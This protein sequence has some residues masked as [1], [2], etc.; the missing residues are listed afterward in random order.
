[1]DV[2]EVAG[3]HIAFERTGAGPGLLLLHGAVCDSR[4]WRHELQ[5]FADDFTVVAWD[6]PG[7]G[8]SSDPPDHFRM[9]DYARCLGGFVDALGLS[10]VHVLGHSWG[11]A[12]A[13]ELYR[14][15]P[16]VVRSLVLAGAYAGW[17]GSLR[18]EEVAARVQFACEVADQLPGGFDPTSMRG[19]FSK[20][21]PADRAAE[22]Q[23]I[24]SEIR[25][26][27][28]RVMAYSLADADLRDV[29]PRIDVP[30]L[31]LYGDADERSPVSVARSLHAAIPDSRLTIMAGLGHESFLESAAT[32]A[33]EVRDFLTKVS[34]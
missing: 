13:L 32:F 20:A 9:P 21:M 14:Q 1:M 8:R 15:Q 27:G 25:P 6:A 31:L 4:V 17:A 29:L 2:V 22:L 24:M 5:A 3:L 16:S 33:A 10:P 19:L 11:S 23:A 30:T 12:L 26:I 34:D 7:C 18:P 28:T